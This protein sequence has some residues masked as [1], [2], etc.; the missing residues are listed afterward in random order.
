MCKV[1][2]FLVNEY[3]IPVFDLVHKNKYIEGS[4]PLSKEEFKKINIQ[5]LNFKRLSFKESSN[6]TDNFNFNSI[7]H[8][9]TSLILTTSSDCSSDFF[10]MIGH[11]E[12]L[13]NLEICN[14]Y[15]KTHIIG[16]NG[17]I[18]SLRN[19]VN[20][21]RIKIS[22]YGSWDIKN[23]VKNIADLP[24][25]KTLILNHNIYDWPNLLELEKMKSLRTLRFS[26]GLKFPITLLNSIGKLDKLHLRAICPILPPNNLNF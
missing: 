3:Q 8:R 26:N 15:G 16:I 17:E 13:Q 6:L 14:T 11:I 20:L 2:S 5:N 10:K 7:G 23:L 24:L 18:S 1:I 4:V 9:I 12:S 19:L 21:K 25:L 22:C